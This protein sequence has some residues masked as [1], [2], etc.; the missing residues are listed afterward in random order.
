[1]PERLKISRPEWIDDGK[2]NALEAPT[3]LSALQ[4][5]PEDRS[6]WFSRVPEGPTA[7]GAEDKI[8]VA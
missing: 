4:M 2:H 5:L 6:N 7:K 1:L 8:R 3:K